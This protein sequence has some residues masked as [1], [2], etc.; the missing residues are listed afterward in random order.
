METPRHIRYRDVVAKLRLSSEALATIRA[1][2]AG[3]PEREVCG[4]L[5]GDGADVRIAVPANNVADNPF[6]CFEIDPSALIA[7]L[8]S[9]RSGGPKL[10]GYYHSHPRGLAEPSAAD[11]ACSSGDG[12]I[13]LIV[14]GDAVTGW[15]RGA[16]GFTP[17]EIG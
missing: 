15:R 1:H 14:A 6:H 7:A 17:V 13:W 9:E 10:L 4:L 11:L 8:R 3:D 2:A 5:L 12:K 16:E